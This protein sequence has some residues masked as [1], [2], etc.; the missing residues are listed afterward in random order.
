MASPD[1][2]A[3]ED[4]QKRKWVLT[5]K[6][7]FHAIFPNDDYLDLRPYQYGWEV[8]APLHSFGPFIR[9]HFLFHYVISGYGTLYSHDS[10]GEIH[11][12]RL[13]EDQGFLI[14]PRQINLYTAD[15]TQPWTYVWLEFDGMRVKEN[16]LKAG[17]AQDSPIYFPQSAKQGQMLRDQMLY[18]TQNA[19][20]ST[21]HLVGRLFMFLDGL[22]EFSANRRETNDKKECDYYIHEAVIY[23]QQNYQ[24]QLSVEEVADFCKLNRNYFSRRFKELVG[25]TPQ[26]FLIQQR[27][28]N[29]ARLLRLT[30]LP[31]KNVADQ[32]GYP[33]QLH[34]SQAFKKHYGL[35]PREWRRQNS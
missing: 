26:G 5:M 20:R 3:L 9:E 27:L 32:C 25:S 17:L 14:C 31:I 10:D 6:D 30:D 4:Q 8:C 7:H 34:F 22:I 2:P 33:N 24:R 1:S 11:E 13:G 15:E 16:L 29:A 28:T 23:I 12:Y 35:P 19:S 21:L 18:F